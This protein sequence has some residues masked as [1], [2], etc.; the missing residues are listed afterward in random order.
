ML[1]ENSA[2]NRLHHSRKAAFCAALLTAAL[3]LPAWP[4]AHFLL[5]PVQTFTIVGETAASATAV[6]VWNYTTSNGDWQ[7]GYGTFT[8]THAFLSDI[9]YG[10]LTYSFDTGT[11]R[12][13]AF[14]E[15][16]SF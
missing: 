7:T 1:K 10:V 4:L 13:G 12:D 11:W 15:T 6:L 14:Y 2:M 8:V 9:W 3:A 16:F 5:S